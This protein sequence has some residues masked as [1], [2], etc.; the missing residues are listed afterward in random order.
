[1]DA[2]ECVADMYF[3]KSIK[4]EE[5]EKILQKM[6]EMNP[7]LNGFEKLYSYAYNVAYYFE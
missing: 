7:G 5:V 4:Q 6:I 2:K 1:M 3:D